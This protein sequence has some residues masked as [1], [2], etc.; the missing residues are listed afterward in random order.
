M[1]YPNVDIFIII[2]TKFRYGL[3]YAYYFWISIFLIICSFYFILYRLLCWHFKLCKISSFP[4]LFR[5]R[6]RCLRACYKLRSTIK[7]IAENKTTPPCGTFWSTCFPWSW[8]DRCSSSW[9]ITYPF[10]CPWL[11]DWTCPWS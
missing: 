10:F 5:A 8:R 4:V 2:L 1:R 9:C 11:L 6:R 7:L 3:V